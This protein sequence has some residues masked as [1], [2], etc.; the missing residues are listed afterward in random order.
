MSDDREI[1]D[2]MDR[3]FEAVE[4]KLTNG[5]AA[6]PVVQGQALSLLLKHVRILVRRNTVTED[7]CQARHKQVCAQPTQPTMTAG[8]AA[9]TH[10]FK[11]APPWLVIG[12]YLVAK[13]NGWIQ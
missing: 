2:L 11:D 13:A 8:A 12:G 3:D 1:R 6:D 5:G 9:V 10:L 7:E 4:R